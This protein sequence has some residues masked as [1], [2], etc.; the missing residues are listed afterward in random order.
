MSESPAEHLI[1]LIGQAS[2]L[3]YR[4]ILLVGPAGTGKTETLLRVE[5][6]TGFPRINLN[7]AISG[8]LLELTARQRIIRLPTLLTEL[9]SSY[10]GNVI[11][12]D[13]LEVLFDISL[14]QDPLRLL[15]KLSRQQTVVAAWPG[16]IE[17]DKL[18]YAKPFYPEYRRYP[19]QD[20]LLVTTSL[21]RADN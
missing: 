7:L 13:N 17:A 15:Q 19:V 14:K 18:V 4:L 9:L 3:Y 1:N 10:K 6:Y 5:E 8:Q 11:L 2:Q 20:F 12:L 21:P 16:A